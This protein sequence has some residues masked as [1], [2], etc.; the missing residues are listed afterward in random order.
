MQPRTRWVIFGWV[1]LAVTAVL[2]AASIYWTFVSPTHERASGLAIS[3][4]ILLE[5]LTF[6]FIWHKSLSYGTTEGKLTAEAEKYLRVRMR[7][8]K[9]LVVLGLISLILVFLK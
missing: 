1:F 5:G 7:R 8:A 2:L 6:M 9:V 4:L 3:A